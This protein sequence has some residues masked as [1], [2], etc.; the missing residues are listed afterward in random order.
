[1]ESTFGH[2][3]LQ[4]S[5]EMNLPGIITFLVFFPFLTLKAAGGPSHRDPRESREQWPLP[6]SFLSTNLR[7]E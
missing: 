5:F 7:S 3:P 4:S 2:A 6:Y 1:M